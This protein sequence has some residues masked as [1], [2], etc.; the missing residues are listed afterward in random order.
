M[1]PCGHVLSCIMLCFSCLLVDKKHLASP[2]FS[3]AWMFSQRVTTIV[4]LST[5][6]NA[7]PNVLI[8][9]SPRLRG[10]KQKVVSLG[11]M[12]LF[13]H[14]LSLLKAARCSGGSRNLT[15]ARKNNEVKNTHQHWLHVLYCDWI[16]RIH[17]KILHF[18]CDDNPGFIDIDI[19]NFPS[20]RRKPIT[21]LGTHMP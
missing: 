1:K 12:P 5:L 21:V 17:A 14:L 11:V 3:L 20:A 6:G 10:F 18:H 13:L 2:N 16:G 15:A 19:Q 9:T 8:T 4:Y 7:T